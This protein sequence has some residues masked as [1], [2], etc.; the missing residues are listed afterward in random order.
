MKT[1]RT[2]LDLFLT[3]GKIG[4]F[5]FGGGYA[6]IP[7]I[8]K[9]VVETKKWITTDDI[10][11]ILAIAESTPGPI[12]INTATF[13]GYRIAG[14]LGA[15][16]ATLGV[17]LPS[18]FIILALSYVI[19]EFQELKPVQYAFLGIRAGVLALIIKA[20]WSM[21]AQCP[22]SILSYLLMLTAFIA[23]AF[24]NL[25]IFPVIIVCALIG[26]VSSCLYE[27]RTRQ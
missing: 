26:L 11:E 4:T 27:R 8:Q 18:F 17:V 6:M 19:R 15:I 14:T 5:T 25:S 2:A 13:V 1:S 7:L 23:V 9:E 12:A 3:F 20:M 10:L 16:C 21:Y 22:K 24:F